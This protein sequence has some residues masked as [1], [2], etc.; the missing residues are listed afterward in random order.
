MNCNKY[1]TKD[2]QIALYENMYYR[3]KMLQQKI[4]IVIQIGH[5]EQYFYNSGQYRGLK[6]GLNM[7][8]E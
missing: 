3:K 1:S 5:S 8:S 2:N 6:R 7:D 4:T